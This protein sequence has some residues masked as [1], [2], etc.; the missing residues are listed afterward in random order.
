MLVKAIM[1][2]S[3][4]F[5]LAYMLFVI[6]QCGAPIQGPTF[7]M[8]TLAKQCVPDEAILGMGFA[9]GILTA[10]TDLI[11]AILPIPIIRT[12]TKPFREKAMIV[13]ILMIG[14]V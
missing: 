11:F 1:A 7:W 10:A 14:T 5:G 3:V 12:S 2:I 8:K 13:G 6:F 4:T 9:H